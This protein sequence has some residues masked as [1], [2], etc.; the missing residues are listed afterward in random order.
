[1]G[2]SIS[3]VMRRN[4]GSSALVAS[5]RLARK[6]RG[7]RKVATADYLTT[8]LTPAAALREKP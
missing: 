2:L 7:F 1:M 6:A 5:A 8:F 4:A 3:R